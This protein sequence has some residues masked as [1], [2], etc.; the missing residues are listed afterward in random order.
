MKYIKANRSFG[1][2]I[3]DIV[4][5]NFMEQKNFGNLTTFENFVKDSLKVGLA[6]C[7]WKLSQSK[8]TE[9]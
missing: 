1:G 9:V 8:R 4:D 7:D 3:G 5:A 6:K 2:F